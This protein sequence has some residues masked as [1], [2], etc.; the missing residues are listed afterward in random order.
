MGQTELER[1]SCFPCIFDALTVNHIKNVNPSANLRKMMITPGGDI[2]PHLVAEA[3]KEPTVKIDSGDLATILTAVS[4]V[5]G[6]AISSAGEIQ[7]QLR[8]DGGTFASGSNHV[9]MNAPKGFLFI[10]EITAEQD[11]EEGALLALMFYA[12]RDG[13]N[14]PLVINVGQSLTGSVG[15]NGLFS[16]GPVIYEG[17]E[18]GGV[19]RV[20]FATG[21]EYTTKRDGGN[22]TAEVGSI[23]KRAPMFEISGSN[24]TV[25]SDVGFGLSAISSGTTIYFIKKG[26]APTDPVHV[27]ITIDSGSY[28]IPD[29]SGGTQDDVVK[30]LTVTGAKASTIVAVS[31]TATL[32]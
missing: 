12:L 13:S 24:L 22:T 1:Y 29:I 30:S 14:A 25:A 17:T 15:V 10:E 16:I 28:E 11:S 31:T 5:N 4:A 18:I 8:A 9:T 32:P 19:Q 20:R 3:M 21:I 2:Q 6:L 7:Y 23:T 27:S 26:A